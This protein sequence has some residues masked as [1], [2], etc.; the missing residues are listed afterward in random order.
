MT[1]TSRH[2]PP[3]CCIHQND[4]IAP[5]EL[6]FLPMKPSQIRRHP[7]STTAVDSPFSSSSIPYDATATLIPILDAFNHRHRNQHR[8]SHWWPVFRIL[9][10][11]VSA[12]AIEIQHTRT[13]SVPH[14]RRHSRDDDSAPLPCARWFDAHLVG[15]AYVQV[16]IPN[17]LLPL[18]N[19]PGVLTFV[20]LSYHPVHFH[21]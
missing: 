14:S 17:P 3:A 20:L 7:S 19:V 21:N 9:R 15:R 4:K 11:S 12:L 13:G 18:A 2:P 6:P 16:S 1:A 10:R 5:N 8:A